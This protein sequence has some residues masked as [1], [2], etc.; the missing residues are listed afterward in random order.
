MNVCGQLHAP[1]GPSK[2]R[3]SPHP[4]FPLSRMLG[5]PSRQYG[6]FGVKKNVLPLPGV[7]PRFFGCADRSV[8]TVLSELPAHWL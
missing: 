1:A 6:Y 5:G 2:E 8:V 4:K 7:K 3:A